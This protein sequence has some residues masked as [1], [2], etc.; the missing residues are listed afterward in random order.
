MEEDVMKT[1][2]DGVSDERGGEVIEY[3]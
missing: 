3:A 2:L 1:L